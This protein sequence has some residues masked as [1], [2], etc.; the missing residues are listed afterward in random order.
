LQKHKEIVLAGE[1]VYL[2]PEGAMYWLK[3]QTLIIADWH[4]GKTAHFRKEGIYAPKDLVE[5]D[6][7]KMNQLL[8]SWPISKVIIAGDLFH[9]RKND[10]W[11]NFAQFITAHNSV[12]WQLVKGNHDI[13]PQDIYA[14]TNLEVI[15]NYLDLAPFR[16]QHYPATEAIENLLYGISGHIHPAI[17]I[18]KGM[19]S[20]VKLPCFH[21]GEYGMVLPAFGVFTGCEV[22]VPTQSDRVYAIAD[23]VVMQIQ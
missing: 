18:G 2:L 3:E 22:I 9:S 10:A 19:V 5:A 4:L 15:K 11:A 16:I 7:V 8:S 12:H 23:D 20:R 17:S 21:C 14:S 6:L 1:V 13:L